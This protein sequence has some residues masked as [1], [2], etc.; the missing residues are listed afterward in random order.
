MIDQSALSDDEATDRL[1]H[2][3][4]RAIERLFNRLSATWGRDFMDQWAG[5]D[6]RKVMLIWAHELSGYDA[7][8]KPNPE[9][10][11]GR[12]LMQPIGWALENLPE[13]PLNAIQFRALCRRAPAPEVVCLPGAPVN[14]ARMAEALA[15]L[16]P[17]RKAVRA[18]VAASG[19]GWAHKLLEKHERGEFVN[20]GP[21]RLA[22]EALGLGGWHGAA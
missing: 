16:A 7:R 13:K 5:L 1:L 4:D 14:P 10:V 15:A 19:K 8:T 21:L 17:V 22:R 9:A 6:G 18:G 3:F 12:A 20:V 2:P 11:D